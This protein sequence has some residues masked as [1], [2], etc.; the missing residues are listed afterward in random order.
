MKEKLKKLWIPT[1]LCAIILAAGVW[2]QGINLA[3]ANPSRIQEPTACS[4]QGTSATSLATSSVSY[5]LGTLESST[6][7]TTCNIG[8][9]GLGTQVWDSAVL[10]IQTYASSSPAT[11]FNFRIEYSNDGLDWY[12][13]SYITAGTTTPLYQGFNPVY[14]WNH[15]A[16]ST[17]RT[18]AS[19][20]IGQ[21][22]K[23]MT[24]NLKTEQRFVRVIFSL[25]SGSNL[26]AVWANIVGK[27]EM[28]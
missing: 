27:V 14:S 7:T 17:S 3:G 24:V 22:Y 9:A 1:L 28:K 25:A 12:G 23:A 21:S 16:T 11:T 6:A 4:T 13:E 8:L 5:L 10:N 15:G 2:F 19:G 18:L 20:S 26:G